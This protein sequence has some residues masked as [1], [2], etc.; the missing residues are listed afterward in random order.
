MIFDEEAC[1]R[2]GVEWILEL[3]M[4]HHISFQHY[5]EKQSKKLILCNRDAYNLF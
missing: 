4:K 2:F 5:Y 1:E 3:E